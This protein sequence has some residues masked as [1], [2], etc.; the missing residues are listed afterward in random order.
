MA[1]GSEGADLESG[2]RT[3]GR[4]IDRADPSL[5]NYSC[6]ARIYKRYAA[7]FT[8]CLILNIENVLQRGRSTEKELSVFTIQTEIAAETKEGQTKLDEYF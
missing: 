5:N 2:K 4:G 8:K 3:K 1:D 7:L 6:T